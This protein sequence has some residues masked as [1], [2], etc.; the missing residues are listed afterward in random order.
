[1]IEFHW[2][3]LML[4]NGVVRHKSYSLT[5]TAKCSCVVIRK[6]QNSAICKEIK[7]VAK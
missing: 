1:M 2:F 6:E 5:L 7:A 4:N 3:A